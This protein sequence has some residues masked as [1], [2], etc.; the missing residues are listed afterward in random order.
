MYSEVMTTVTATEAVRDFSVL[1]G[2]VEHGQ[3]VQIV[4]HG[5]P[6]ARLTPDCG[7]MSGQKVAA[8]FRDHQPDPEAAEAIA[9]NLRRAKEEEDDALAHRY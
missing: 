2:L 7:F 6:V 3:T 8:L 9:A 4:R 1:L 5:R